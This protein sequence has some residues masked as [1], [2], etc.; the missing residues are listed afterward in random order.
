MTNPWIESL[1]FAADHITASTMWLR[2]INTLCLVGAFVA[3]GAAFRHWRQSRAVRGGG[4][5]GGN[6][7]AHAAVVVLMLAVASA[8]SW[9]WSRYV[10]VNHFPSQTMAEVL[11]M[12]SSSLLVSV[13]LLHY[14]LKLGR[15]GHGWAIVDDSLLILVFLGVWATNTYTTTLSTAQRDL[16]P[17]LQSYWFPPHLSALIFSYA[18]LG[19]AGAVCLVYFATRFWSGV[20]SGGRTKLSQVMVL[21]LLALMP[22]AHFVSLPVLAIVGLVFLGLKWSGNLPG[23][24]ALLGLEKTMDQV[25]Y[26]AFAVG[27]PFLTAGLFMGAF[28]AQEAWANY[29]GW[30]SKENSALMS[31]LVYVVYIHLRMLGGYRGERA[32]VVLMGGALSI[33]LTFQVF[34]YLPDSQKSLHRYTDDGVVPMEGRQGG[35]EAPEDSA[36]LERRP[37]A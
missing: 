12:F 2:V 34:G 13:L 7:L 29:W 10:E 4:E 5:G 31:W 27:I 3:A 36:R 17:A 21:L 32:M 28:W 37:D 16:P 23:K 22:F 24:E 26:R 18:T 33:F 9:M 19:I 25:S 20:F 35:G 6:P 1:N 30:D 15:I 11:V 14:A 8:G